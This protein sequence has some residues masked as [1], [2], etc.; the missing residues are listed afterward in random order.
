VKAAV[1]MNI[2][3]ASAE[4]F[5]EVQGTGE[6]G[7]F[8]RSQLNALLD[9]ASKGIAELDGWQRRVLGVTSTQ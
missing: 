7:T 8:S 2:V 4:S 3:M 9:L 5:V 1:D 6:H